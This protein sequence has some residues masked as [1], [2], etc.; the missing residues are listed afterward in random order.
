MKSKLKELRLNK[1]LTLKELSNALKEKGINISPD[2]LAKYERGDRKP[3]MDKLIQLANF[4]N[5]SVLDL[6][7]FK[8]EKVS[9]AEYLDLIKNRPH[10]EYTEALVAEF[11]RKFN[12]SQKEKINKLKNSLIKE[13]KTQN[14]SDVD[15]TLLSDI[16]ISI[17]KVNAENE[18]AD[19]KFRTFLR[20]L[21]GY[22]INKEFTQDE[23]TKNL[24]R[25]LSSLN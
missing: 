9:Q 3:K 20:T 14:L 16:L 23:I 12:N 7:G 4:F 10:D 8:N 5:V 1:G 25:F 24:E 21:T 22:I 2:S 13:I 18:I 17:R 11:T 19:L 6:Q 15:L